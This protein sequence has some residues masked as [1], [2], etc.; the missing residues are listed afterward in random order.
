MSR[1]AEREFRFV[2]PRSVRMGGDFEE[3]DIQMPIGA[4]LA[5]NYV[6]KH[7]GSTFGM[8]GPTKFVPF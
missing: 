7:E 3:G 4:G 6:P 8:I 5:H 1:C 2:E